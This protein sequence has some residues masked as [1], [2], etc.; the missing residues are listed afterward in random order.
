MEKKGVR[1]VEIRVH[2]KGFLKP[3]SDAVCGVCWWS[4]PNTSCIQIR[5][6]RR[7]RTCSSMLET[8]LIAS[9][10]TQTKKK[11]QKPENATSN[12]EEETQEGL[13]T[14]FIQLS[15]WLATFLSTSQFTA[16]WLKSRRLFPTRVK[17]FG[18]RYWTSLTFKIIGTNWLLTSDHGTIFLIRH[19]LLGP[20]PSL[21]GTKTAR[22]TQVRLSKSDLLTSCLLPPLQL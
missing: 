8:S 14:V 10:G 3:A 20:L 9:D 7:S 16:S 21:V 17:I 5:S 12:T 13:G 19:K 15:S 18:H 2:M 1:S 22:L 6:R 11:W 4:Q